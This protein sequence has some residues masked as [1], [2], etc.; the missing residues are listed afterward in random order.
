MRVETPLR[1]QQRGAAL[2]VSLI[3][4]V[5]VTL[6][7]LSSLHTGLLEIV[8]SG[9]EEARTTAFQRA[10]SGIESLTMDETNF[11]VSG[12]VGDSD[13]TASMSGETCDQ[14]NLSFPTGFD[15]A[16]HWARI[17]RLNPEF[18]CPPRMFATSCDIFQVAH[19]ST[20]S[21][22]TDVAS[23]GGRSEIVQGF[24]VLVPTPGE[25]KVIKDSSVVP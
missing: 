19:F 10:Q 13:C 6:V 12:N 16:K 7:S 23:R 17:E 5:G 25:E 9:N 1:M 21:R 24:M 8:M 18:S 14:T 15:T 3:L 2:V 22:Y 4:L 20:D 11:K